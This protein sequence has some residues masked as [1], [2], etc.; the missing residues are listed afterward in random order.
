MAIVVTD[1]KNQRWLWVWAL[2]SA[3]TE[4]GSINVSLR[5]CAKLRMFEE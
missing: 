4:R 3:M 1:S 5:L 2:E